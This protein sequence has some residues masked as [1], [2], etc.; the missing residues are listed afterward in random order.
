VV[1]GE[2]AD[3]LLAVVRESLANATKHAEAGWLEIRV[4]VG[5]DELVL[6][7]EDDG[8]GIPDARVAAVGDD[9]APG[10]GGHGLRNL[11]Q[12]AR[13]LGGSMDV[14]RPAAGGTLVVWRVPL[15]G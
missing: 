13:R 4:R 1:P 14:L 5:G 9:G 6:E 8:R 10:L 11:R 7:V 2:V 3:Q 12:R 15:D